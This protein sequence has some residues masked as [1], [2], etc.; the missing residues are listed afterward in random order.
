MFCLLGA[1]D[2]EIAGIYNVSEQTIN[3]WKKQHPEFLESIKRGKEEAD[4]AIAASLY[5]RAKGFVKE[6]CEEVFVY[7]GQVVRARVKKYFPPD[8]SAQIFF[9]K[10]RQPQKWRDK[11]VQT[12][13]NPDGTAL[14]GN[15]PL[16]K[17]QLK[18]FN[19][20]LEQTC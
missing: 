12:L 20:E 2:K 10:N 19:D 5:N 17:T 1:T 9:L 13:E 3:A 14:F 18:K 8:V 11:Q 15:K 4:A 16:S 7:K 6:N